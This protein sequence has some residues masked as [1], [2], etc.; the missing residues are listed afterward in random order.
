MGQRFESCAMTYNSLILALKSGRQ[1]EQALKLLEKA[2]EEQVKLTV[3]N[4][5][6]AINVCQDMKDSKRAEELFNEMI[7]DGLIPNRMTWTALLKVY[8]WTNE[9]DKARQVFKDLQEEADVTPTAVMYNVI[10]TLLLRNGLWEE[11]HELIREGSRRGILQIFSKHVRNAI[12]CNVNESAMILAFLDVILEERMRMF[13]Q[14]GSVR[15]LGLVPNNLEKEE[16]HVQPKLEEYFRLCH[17]A[18]EA[19]VFQGK[20]GKSG[21]MWIKDDSLQEWMQFN[22]HKVTADEVTNHETL[23]H[24][25]EERS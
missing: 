6:T 19:K 12:E 9:V 24:L 22:V 15:P 17:P 20:S 18:L 1:Y 11:A 23:E 16:Y 10:C 13:A 4:Y 5:T 7:A 25:E 8:G 21:L 3:V 2:R 14:T